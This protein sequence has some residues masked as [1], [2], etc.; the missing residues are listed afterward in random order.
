MGCV[1]GDTLEFN[2]LGGTLFFNGGPSYRRDE[3]WGEGTRKKNVINRAWTT[4]DSGSF[5]SERSTFFCFR[6]LCSVG[7]GQEGRKEEGRQF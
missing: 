2:C 4:R 3:G 7:L 1:S 6:L 5:V